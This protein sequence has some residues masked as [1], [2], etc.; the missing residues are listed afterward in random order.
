MAP[1]QGP[2]SLETRQMKHQ[3]LEDALKMFVPAQSVP[4]ISEYQREQLAIKANYERLKAERLARHKSQSRQGSG[5][6]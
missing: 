4:T 5:D 3:I 2:F 1:A 6:G